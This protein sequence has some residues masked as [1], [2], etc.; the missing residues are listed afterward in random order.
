MPVPGHGD[1]GMGSRGSSARVPTE[2]RSPRRH[3]ETR[4]STERSRAMSKRGALTHSQN[5]RW[6]THFEELVF[7]SNAWQPERR[8]FPI[9]V[10]HLSRG[11]R[12]SEREWLDARSPSRFMSEVSRHRLR[13]RTFGKGVGI[14]AA[15]MGVDLR[16]RLSRNPFEQT[17]SEVTPHSNKGTTNA[18]TFTRSIIHF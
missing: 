7:R 13:K 16:K 17:G 9:H 4:R 3:R 11:I 12:L 1:A 15:K 2:C 6:W 5:R 18:S 14:R 8:R 10:R